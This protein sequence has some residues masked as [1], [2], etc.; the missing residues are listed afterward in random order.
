MTVAK[1]VL[2]ILSIR[3]SDIPE[4]LGN[5]GYLVASTSPEKLVFKELI[6]IS[7]SRPRQCSGN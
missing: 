6:D 7:T 2:L 4:I 3:I 1:R 5:T